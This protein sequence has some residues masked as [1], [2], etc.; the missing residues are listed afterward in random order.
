MAKNKTKSGVPNKHL[1]A[2]ISYLQQAAT[3]LTLHKQPQQHAKTT[4]PLDSG[5]ITSL[6][7]GT[8]TG[9]IELPR[10]I[11]GSPVGLTAI[12][13]RSTTFNV[14]PS[15]GLLHHLSNH[16]RQ[17]AQKSQIRLH[18][19]VKHSICKICSAILIEGETSKKYIENLSRGGRKPHADVLVLECGVCGSKKRFPTGAKRQ[20]RKSQRQLQARVTEAQAYSAEPP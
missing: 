7:S 10:S 6:Q 5:N 1:H 17:V 8:E 18:T 19:S 20:L 11:T 12:E 3:Y 16:L 9:D 4:K 14:Q 13:G 2:R 15:G